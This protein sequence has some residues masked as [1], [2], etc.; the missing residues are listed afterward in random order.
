MP[1]IGTGHLWILLLEL[2]VVGAIV[3]GVVAVVRRPSA[4]MS[5][6]QRECPACKERMRR[7]ASICPHCRTPSTPR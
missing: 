6:N 2:L 3:Y 1:F 5:R 4:S 7:D